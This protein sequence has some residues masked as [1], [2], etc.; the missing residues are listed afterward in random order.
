MSSREY[1]LFQCDKCNRQIEL[2]ID[3]NRIDPIRCIITYKCRGKLSRGS[4]SHTKKFLVTPPV[5]GLQNYIQRGAV[6]SSAPIINPLPIASINTGGING[7]GMITM[8]VLKKTQYISTHDYSVMGLNNQPILINTGVN[9]N[10]Q[11]AQNVKMIL[12]IFPISSSILQSTTYT[13]LRSGDVHVLSGADNSPNNI[14]LR[15][16]NSNKI[17]VYVNGIEMNQSSYILSITNQSITFTPSIYESNNVI[18]VIVYNEISVNVSKSSI[19]SLVF[20][21][22]D[23]TINLPPPNI[24]DISYLNTS[25]WG[26]YASV[27]IL[28]QTQYLMHCTNLSALSNDI[29]YGV[30]SIQVVIGAPIANGSFVVGINYTINYIGTTDWQ[31]VG[32]PLNISIGTIF[33]ATKTGDGLI[34]VTTGTAIASTPID[35]LL[36]DVN[37]LIG[38]NPYNFSDKELNVYLNASTIDSN[39]EFTYS[40]DKL[41]GLYLMTAPLSYFT[42]LLHPMLPT[43]Q[44][45]ATLFTSQNEVASSASQSVSHSYILGPI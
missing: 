5:S 34:P 41:S 33:T 15:F 2:Q 21:V 9:N 40:Q 6:I 16:S 26:N 12:N 38:K 22:L 18:N 25:S 10:I 23:P 32:A 13:Y 31:A 8:A 14:V 4:I 20:D 43:N 44:F 24:S 19:I 37:F 39:F 11:L 36:S 30:D 29:S 27:D 28:N 42:Q 1:I 35:I 7:A 45:T 3:D 17:G